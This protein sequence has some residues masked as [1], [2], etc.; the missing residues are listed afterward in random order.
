MLA[1]LSSPMPSTVEAVVAAAVDQQGV[2]VVDHAGV[3]V[4]AAAVVGRALVLG[5]GHL[6]GVAEAGGVPHVADRAA[7]G[8]RLLADQPAEGV[9]IASP[10][11]SF[12][13]TLTVAPA[14]QGRADRLA[15][16]EAD[17]D[18]RDERGVG[19]G[20]AEIGAVVAVADDQR[21]GAG[22]RG[23]LGLRLERAPAAVDHGDLAR[24]GGRVG[25]RRAAVGRRTGRV[26]VGRLGHVGRDDDVAGDAGGASAAHRTRRHRSG[27]PWRSTRGR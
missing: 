18:G 25:V 5:V 12:M 2:A 13:V 16:G 7:E 1:A 23:D 8:R 27:S 22:R 26:G 17:A 20:H 15:V 10:P 14:G 3:A 21:R 4:H 24:H 11:A 6:A 9:V 19:A